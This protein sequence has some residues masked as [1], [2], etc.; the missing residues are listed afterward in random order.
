SEYAPSLYTQGYATSLHD[1][2]DLYWKH[3]RHVAVRILLRQALPLY[4]RLSDAD[5]EGRE[6]LASCLHDLGSSYATSWATADRAV[7]PLREAYELRMELSARDA[8]H[9][10]DLANTC[11]ELSRALLK[12]SRFRD[13]VRISEHEVRLRRRLIIAD[14]AGHEQPLCHA[15]LRLADGRAMA[16]DEAAAWRTARQAEEACQALAGRPG[17]PPDQIAW[18]LCRLAGTL[19]LCGRHDGRRAV[20]AVEPARRAVR[21]YRRMVDQDPSRQADLRWA[22]SRLATVLDRLGRHAEATDVQ[23]RRGA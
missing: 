14:R 22:V 5:E 9:E 7:P 3:D 15:L 21:L 12:T 17:E 11:A 18:F 16:G 20:R 6:G 19:S 13:A 10:E 2:S 23:L 4:R 1:G 8:T